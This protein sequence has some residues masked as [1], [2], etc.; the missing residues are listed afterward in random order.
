MDKTAENLG[1][2][3]EIAF[4]LGILSY[5]NQ[6]DIKHHYHNIYNND[7]KKLNLNKIENYLLKESQVINPQDE[8]I[9]RE[10][11]LFFLQKGFL[12]G[13]N[14]IREYLSLIINPKKY[15]RLEIVYCQCNFVEDNSFSIKRDIGEKA[16]FD[17][18][19]SQ[20][21]DGYVD[22]DRYSKMGEFL[23]ADTLLFIY[24]SLHK[25]YHLLVVDLSIFS[26]KSYGDLKDLQEIENW[27]QILLTEVNYLRS[28]STFSRLNIDTGGKDEKLD[29]DFSHDLSQYYQGLKRKDKET[30]K[31]I[32]A[33]SYGYSFHQFLHKQKMISYDDKL[34]IN[35]MGYSD[36]SINSITVSLDNLELLATCH[37]IYPQQK[38]G[39]MM[40]GKEAIIKTIKCNAAKSFTSERVKDTDVKRQQTTGNKQQNIEEN[41]TSDA[42]KIDT[43]ENKQQITPSLVSQSPLNPPLLKQEDFI[44]DSIYN[45]P[46]FN[47]KANINLKQRGSLE[48]TLDT[49]QFTNQTSSRE[50]NQQEKVN[51]ETNKKRHREI[52]EGRKFINSL[53]DISTEE[54]K[55]KEINYEETIN[56]FVN[57]IDI[58][59]PSLQNSLNLESNL[60]LRDA[61]SRL[62]TQA[63]EEENLPYLF[64]TGN[65]GIGKTTA[66]VEFLKTHFDDGFI[67]LYISPRTQVNLDIIN[68]FQGIQ[69]QELFAINTNANLIKSNQGKPTIQYFSEII[70]GDFTLK[71][72]NFLEG[73]QDTHREKKLTSGIKQKNEDTWENIDRKSV[74]VLN[75]L[76]QGIDAIIQE[77]KTRHLVATLSI[78][79]LKKLSDSQD[80]LYHLQ[81]I[82][83]SAYNVN[84]A[85]PIPSQMSAMA[86][87]FKH[88]FIMIDEI[89]GDSGGVE[90]LQGISNF[91]RQN[92]LYNNIYGFNPK[93]II[94]D[95]SI[96]DEKVIKQHLGNT[97]VEPDKIYYRK[98]TSEKLALSVDDFEF[99]KHPAKIINTNSF[100]ADSLTIKYQLFIETKKF[101]PSLYKEKNKNL[102][103]RLQQ[104]IINDINTLL[105][106][107]NNQ[108]IIVYIQDKKRLQELISQLQEINPNFREYQDYLQI[109]S[110]NSEADKQKIKE[111]QNQAKII[112]MTASGSRGLSF[113]KTRHILVDIPR[114]NIEQNLMEIIQVIY[115]GRG[116]YWE[117]NC[118]LTNDDKDKYLYFY[119][120]VE[121]VFYDEDSAE[122]SLQE[123]ILN[124]INLLI[125]LKASIM[126]R[127]KGYGDIGKHQYL[128]IPLAGKSV[129]SVG[130]TFSSRMKNLIILLEKEYQNNFR[131]TILK[132]VAD[133]LKSLLGKTD[134][135]LKWIDNNPQNKPISY[136]NIRQSFSDKFTKAIKNN[137]AELLNLDEIELSFISGN[138]LIIPLKQRQL[139]ET[140]ELK[141]ET[142]VTEKLLSK[143]RYIN[144]NKNYH[145]N[146][147]IAVYN[148]IELLEKMNQ[149]ELIIG[150]F[151]QSSQQFD[152]YYA[153]PFLILIHPHLIKQ[154]LEKERENK[155]NQEDTFRSILETYIR[156][157]FPLNNALP[158]GNYYKEF[159]FLLFNSFTFD[160]L[161][162]KLFTDKQIFS[163]T[164]LNI[165]N[166]ILCESM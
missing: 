43:G 46:L 116:E 125:L 83:N 65:P 76:C 45:L 124:V 158:I 151:Q 13:F 166:L 66:I 143:L 149:E 78:Q 36:R 154:Y 48:A 21:T 90:F 38:K 163:S 119:L 138:M 23:R 30:F 141:L 50:A 73:N 60:T 61:H 69:R 152:Q 128:I 107:K 28:K 123:N 95:A 3:F 34:I 59:P 40:Q 161:R 22:I 140:Y 88:F 101:T 47:W 109:H 133:E 118:K 106:D 144:Q 155:L 51:R 2:V 117:N 93:I 84:T 92:N 100:P 41:F 96:V 122:L 104:T 8:R 130:E 157:I 156:Y 146:L 72:V 108:Q 24:N 62:I 75:S 135:L 142:E 49:P 4:N 68:K 74:G 37:H 39:D 18:I 29:I 70:N 113:P 102:Y 134:F 52:S 77:E 131:S 26:V 153:F 64:L 79:S 71:T 16:Y 57:S 20:L 15:D 19:L 10:W 136:L 112:F 94:A 67:F 82:F 54:E 121:A 98:V 120:G 159:P 11:I 132:E 114:F 14:L 86:K 160:L 150:K 139:K 89:T 165:L 44:E 56:N 63:L 25:T 32:Q 7:L 5:I 164:E 126:T 145:E 147:N 1:R 81:Q 80:T 35:V 99:K 137:L 87:K 33:G 110:N 91:F 12:S 58:I 111:Y 31:L 97:K 17:L 148:A 27:K 103:S 42:V 53:M 127:I 129:S 9:I 105:Q 55:I 85:K 162:Y 115:R 6:V